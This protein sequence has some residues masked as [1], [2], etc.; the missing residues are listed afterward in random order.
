MAAMVA[1][2]VGALVAAIVVVAGIAAIVGDPAGS[3]DVINKLSSG[4]SNAISYMFTGGP[5]KGTQSA[6]ASPAR[7]SGGALFV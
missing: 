1:E 7:T 6:V 3:K 5:A 2:E 4:I